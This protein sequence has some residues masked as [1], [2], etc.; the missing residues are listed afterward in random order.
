[1]EDLFELLEI[2]GLCKEWDIVV[3]A[4][5]VILKE[6][7]QFLSSDRPGAATHRTTSHRPSTIIF[8]LIMYQLLFLK[9]RQKDY[10]IQKIQYVSLM[11]LKRN[12]L[13]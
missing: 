5:G 11:K 9:H 1:M 13:K 3:F 2:N 10:F 8:L 12:C 6:I 7:N 4:K